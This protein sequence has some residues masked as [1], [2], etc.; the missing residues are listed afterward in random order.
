[1]ILS[2]T[3]QPRLKLL[4]FLLRHRQADI[5]HTAQQGCKHHRLHMQLGTATL[6]L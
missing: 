6:D 1:M 4:V 3:L 5:R 2:D